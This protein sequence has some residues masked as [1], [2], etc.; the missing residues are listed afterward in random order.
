MVR[1]EVVIVPNT[2][3]T[4][5]FLRAL[6]QSLAIVLMALVVIAVLV[7]VVRTYLVM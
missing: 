2:K 7:I 5:Y 6:G 1:R 3:Q 4:S